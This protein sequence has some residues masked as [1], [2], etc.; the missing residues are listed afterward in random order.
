MIIIAH[1]QT[2]VVIS[3]TTSCSSLSLDTS[4]VAPEVPLLPTFPTSAPPS[5]GWGNL[6]GEDCCKIIDDCYNEVIHW[7]HNLFRVPSGSAGN[8]FVSEL[9]CLFQAFSSNGRHA[10][11]YYHATKS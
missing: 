9:S 8:S 2:H 10:F 11:S 3:P 7:R 1:A 5:F 6:D 4:H